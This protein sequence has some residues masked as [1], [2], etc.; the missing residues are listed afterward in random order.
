MTTNINNS[1][2][3]A[4]RTC[5]KQSCGCK[6]TD[7]SLPCHFYT[8]PPV[9]LHSEDETEVRVSD[10]N[11]TTARKEVDLTDEE[12]LKIWQVQVPA[13]DRVYNFARAVIAKLRE[14]EANH[15]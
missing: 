5:T 1:P 15:G 6:D 11:R 14:K 10:G 9:S 3:Y 8:A 4:C 12:L 2:E 7:C 13:S